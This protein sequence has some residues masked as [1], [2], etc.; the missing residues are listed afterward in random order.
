MPDLAFYKQ[1]LTIDE[2][3]KR[4]EDYRKQ[5][6]ELT[7][8]LTGHTLIQDEKAVMNS[9]HWKN[10]GIKENMMVGVSSDLA[11]LLWHMEIV[12]SSIKQ[13]LQSINDGSE[14]QVLSQF[15]KDLITMVAAFKD[16][17]SKDF[18]IMPSSPKLTQ[19]I[20]NFNKDTKKL[21]DK[22][23]LQIESNSSL[24]PMIKNILLLLSVIGTIP[25][26]FSIVHKAKHGSYLFFDQK[27]LS[28]INGLKDA[29]PSTQTKYPTCYDNNDDYDLDHD[30]SSHQRS[31]R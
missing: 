27:K 21:F 18:G 31:C 28:N 17:I 13:K 14:K 23:T 22:Y 15:S 12:E 8:Q 19:C 5:C 2:L 10:W 25:A 9:F 4:Y 11:V 16:K 26:I 7:E 29:L 24:K 1:P 6:R 30:M 3:R 20:T